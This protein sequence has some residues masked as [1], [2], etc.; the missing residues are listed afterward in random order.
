M[1]YVKGIV[2]ALT[3]QPGGHTLQ[4]I[5]HEGRVQV[6]PRVKY[7]TKYIDKVLAESSEQGFTLK[8]VFDITNRENIRLVWKDGQ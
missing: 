5:F 6:Q 1:A 4:L 3:L 7:P 2:N 8:E